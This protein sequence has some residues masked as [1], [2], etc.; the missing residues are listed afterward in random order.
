MVLFK[1]FLIP[2]WFLLDPW[3]FRNMLLISRYVRM[4]QRYSYYWFIIWLHCGHRMYLNSFMFIGICFMA[5]IFFLLLNF[6]SVLANVLCI[7][8][9]MSILS[10]IQMNTCSNKYSNEY[11][12][13]ECFCKHKLGSSWLMVL[14]SCLY[15][16]WFSFYHLISYWEGFAVLQ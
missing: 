1:H 13:M 12:W 6:W 2:L 9:R 10:N 4:C 7:F 8:E 15:Y 16:Y 11:W 14:S 3:V 5:Q